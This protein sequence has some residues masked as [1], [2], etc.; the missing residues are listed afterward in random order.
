M[1]WHYLDKL[2]KLLVFSEANRNEDPPQTLTFCTLEIELCN[3]LHLG[4]LAGQVII[5][6]GKQNTG[7]NVTD[8][9]HPL[10]YSNGLK[11]IKSL[12]VSTVTISL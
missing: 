10:L 6:L 7:S 1:A 8:E 9:S 11:P 5:G 3:S 4:F 2:E 12:N